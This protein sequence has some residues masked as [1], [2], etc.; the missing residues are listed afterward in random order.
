CGRDLEK[1]LTC[2]RQPHATARGEPSRPRMWGGR[3]ASWTN[4][5]MTSMTLVWAEAH[6]EVN[7]VVGGGLSWKPGSPHVWAEGGR[8]PEV[9]PGRLS[10]LR[11]LSHVAVVAVPSCPG[12]DET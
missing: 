8:H 6:A 7:K 9:R 10:R 12:G 11:V 4:P 3:N 5:A 1:E 2:H